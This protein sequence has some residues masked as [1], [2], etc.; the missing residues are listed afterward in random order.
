MRHAPIWHWSLLIWMLT[1]WNF[2]ESEEPQYELVLRGGKII[3]G[4][5]NPWFAGDIAVADQL[6]ADLARENTAALD[7]VLEEQEARQALAGDWLAA[8]ETL[9]QRTRARSGNRQDESVSER[10]FGYLLRLDTATL[11][12]ASRKAR[13]PDWRQWLQMQLA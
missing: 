11:T 2:A 13:D 9:F 1:P 4:T 3:D 6:L 12:E 5:G 7:L 8:A 10:L